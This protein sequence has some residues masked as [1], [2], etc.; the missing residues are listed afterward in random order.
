MRSGAGGQGGDGYRELAMILVTG[1]AGYI[2]SH[3]CIKLML[4]AG[5]WFSIFDNFSNSC[6]EVFRCVQTVTSKTF[7]VVEMDI[8]DRV[9]FEDDC[10]IQLYRRHSICRFEG[11]RQVVL[12]SSRLTR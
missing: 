8:R 1:G 3:T 5:Y 11:A 6:P 7:Q 12:N 2:G 4:N 10:A 9:A